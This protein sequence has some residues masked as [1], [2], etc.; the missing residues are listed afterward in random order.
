MDGRLRKHRIPEQVRCLTWGFQWL[1]VPGEA[2]G[3]STD[4]H[5]RVLWRFAVDVFGRQHMAATRMEVLE[6]WAVGLLA[7]SSSQYLH[8]VA[9]ICPVQQSVISLTGSPLEVSLQAETSSMQ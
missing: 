2:G 3:D 5:S 1:C 6:L 4:L 8:Q 7:I 9:S